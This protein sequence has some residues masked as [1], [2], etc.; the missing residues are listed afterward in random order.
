MWVDDPTL[1]GVQRIRNRERT[2]EHS[3][4]HLKQG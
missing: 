3:T 1:G 4:E 2:E